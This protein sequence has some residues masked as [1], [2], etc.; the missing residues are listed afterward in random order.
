M[1]IGRILGVVG[2]TALGGLGIFLSI[3]RKPVKYSDKWFKSLSR[4]ELDAE[5]EVVVAEWCS[6]RID[7][8]QAVHL[9]SLRRKFDDEI[10]Q[11][12]Y[13]DTGDT[14]PRKHN[15]PPSREHGWNLYKPD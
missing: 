15:Y 11:R 4:E 6:G 9:E 12:D 3:D 7:Y 5:R 14:D 13:G 10:R 2:A 1:K 8:S